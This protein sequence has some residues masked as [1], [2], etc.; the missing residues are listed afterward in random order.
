MSVAEPETGWYVDFRKRRWFC[1]SMD[2]RRM[3]CDS[4]D[5]YMTAADYRTFRHWKWTLEQAQETVP[6]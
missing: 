1:V 6:A 4:E 3:V 5:G 2:R